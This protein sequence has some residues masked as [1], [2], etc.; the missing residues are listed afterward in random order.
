MNLTSL[1]IFDIV[2]LEASFA[3]LLG[4]LLQRIVQHDFAA[5]FQ[6]KFEDKEE[7]LLQLSQTDLNFLLR[8]C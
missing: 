6:R 5:G 7:E 1:E 4:Q 2:E 8:V 3:G